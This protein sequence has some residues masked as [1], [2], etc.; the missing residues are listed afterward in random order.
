MRIVLPTY[1]MVPLLKEGSENSFDAMNTYNVTRYRLL[2][3]TY[4]G[5]ILNQWVE[6]ELT[7][8]DMDWFTPFLLARGQF[9]KFYI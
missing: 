3:P 4:L 2:H 7:K 1:P 8:K 9:H 5:K 6:S